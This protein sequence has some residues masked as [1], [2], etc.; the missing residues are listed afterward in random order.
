VKRDVPAAARAILAA[1]ETGDPGEFYNVTADHM[2]VIDAL[3]DG[4]LVAVDP[5]L[6]HFVLALLDDSYSD[7][8]T[9]DQ[10]TV[11]DLRDI[12]RRQGSHGRSW[13]ARRIFNSK[14]A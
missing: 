11:D 2:A 8:N 12:L 6:L 13:N 3:A 1:H 9:G 7:F 5:R 4:F 14:W 10:D